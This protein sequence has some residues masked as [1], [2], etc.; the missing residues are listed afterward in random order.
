MANYMFFKNCY[1]LLQNVGLK[2]SSN[3]VLIKPSKYA[4]SKSTTTEIM[5]DS[6]D[7]ELSQGISSLEKTLPSEPAI[8]SQNSDSQSHN[9]NKMNISSNTFEEDLDFTESMVKFFY[10]K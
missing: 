1:F 6:I 3:S 5:N 4:T 7:S 9:L 8:E 10:S 2:T